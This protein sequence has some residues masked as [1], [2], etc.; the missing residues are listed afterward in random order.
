MNSSGAIVRRV[1]H[2]IGAA[3]ALIVLSACRVDIT[4][5]LTMAENGS[6]SIAVVA[7]ADAEA[8]RL[9]PE[10]ETS[11]QLEDLQQ[12]GW[13]TDVQPSPTGGLSVTIARNFA[14]PDEASFFLS[15]LSGDAGPLRDMT[16]TRTGGI[17]DARYELNG[18][19]G[20][21]NGL[22]GFAD[23]Q[24][25]T[26]LGAAPFAAA[27]ADRGGVLNDA[28]S[29]SLALTL[30]GEPLESTAVITPRQQD[31]LVTTFTWQI[32]VD[33]TEVVLAATTR[34]RNL[35]ALLAW[36]ASRVFLVLL[37]LLVVAIVLYVA[38]V[39][40]RRSNTTPAS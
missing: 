39:V 15:Q 9:A 32:P 20:I 2:V 7:N 22:A 11:L 6:G 29:M 27:L 21:P 8:V 33:Q 24:A 25:L 4:T 13:V 19:G 28:L 38:T 12:A 34:D 14:T 35:S 23:S 10:L 17:N 30:P 18:I 31:D 40:Y 16:V 26:A 5:T 1:I 3:T 37:I 36:Y